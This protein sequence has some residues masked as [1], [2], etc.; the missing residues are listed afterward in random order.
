MNAKSLI[1][2]SMLAALTASA[3]QAQS[4]LDL[5]DL[6]GRQSQSRVQDN[7]VKVEY[8]IDFHY[9]FDYRSFFVFYT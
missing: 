6:F 4:L 9:F 2:S 5:Q 8:D 1:V 3:V 7:A